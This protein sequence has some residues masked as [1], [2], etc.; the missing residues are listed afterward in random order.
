MKKTASNPVKSVA[1]ECEQDMI[2]APLP[3]TGKYTIEQWASLFGLEKRAMLEN[4]SKHGIQV[5]RFGR[6]VLIDASVF[7]ADLAK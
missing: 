5:I 4:I 1:T 6:T 3:E 7:W 2:R